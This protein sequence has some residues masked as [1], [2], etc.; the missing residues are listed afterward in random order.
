MRTNT[1][2]QEALQILTVASAL[3]HG[4]LKRRRIMS[5]QPKQ[6][7]VTICAPMEFWQALRCLREIVLTEM[8][9]QYFANPDDSFRQGTFR[10]SFDVVD[11]Y[12]H[13][14]WLDGRFDENK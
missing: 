4:Q 7:E 8:Q 10:H 13:G 11:T 3:T 9:Q 1:G 12:L 14:L 5:T 2:P 6:I